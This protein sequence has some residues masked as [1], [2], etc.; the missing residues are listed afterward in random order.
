MKIAVEFQY[1]ERPTALTSEVTHDG[2]VF[3][4]QPAWSEL[5]HDGVIQ[6]TARIRPF[7]TSLKN[8]RFDSTSLLQSGP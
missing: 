3:E 8:C 4:P 5:A 7:L 1:G 2:P 6:L